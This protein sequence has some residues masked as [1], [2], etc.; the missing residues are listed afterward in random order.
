MA[1]DIHLEKTNAG[2]KKM[3][4]FRTKNMIKNKPSFQKYLNYRFF[5][6]WMKE[7]YFTSAIIS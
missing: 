7:K 6:V 2:Q 3:I 4:P 5:Y 1:L